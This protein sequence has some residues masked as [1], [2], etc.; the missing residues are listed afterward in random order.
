MTCV[1]C[2]DDPVV[3]VNCYCRDVTSGQCGRCHQYHGDNWVQCEGKCPVVGSPF[4]D[5]VEYERHGDPHRRL[6]DHARKE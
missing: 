1:Y 5:L 6:P 3:S 2:N 4:F